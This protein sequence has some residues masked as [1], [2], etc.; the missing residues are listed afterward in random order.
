[1]NL[2]ALA[3][4]VA[5]DHMHLAATGGAFP[6]ARGHPAGGVPNGRGR[7]RR[8]KL[9]E[10]L[11]AKAEE[12]HYLLMECDVPLRRVATRLRLSLR[13]VRLLRSIHFSHLEDAL[14]RRVHRM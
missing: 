12:A 8:R 6:D 7:V 13:A 2:E 11:R 1:M 4:R 9:K 3:N 14:M 5:H 10:K